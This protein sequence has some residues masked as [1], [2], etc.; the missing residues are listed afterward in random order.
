MIIKIYKIKINCK[1]EVIFDV[2][3]LFRVII[4]SMSAIHDDCLPKDYV[5]QVITIFTTTS[6]PN[7]NQLFK[8]L[9]LI[10]VL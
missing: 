10:S 8:K 7:F 4:D 5:Q 9:K 6:V 1:G 3:D 2:V